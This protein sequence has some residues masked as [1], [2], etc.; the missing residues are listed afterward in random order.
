MRV[1]L[2]SRL[3]DWD[4]YLDAMR[5][6]AFDVIPTPCRSADVESVLTQS[7]RDLRGSVAIPATNPGPHRAANA[8]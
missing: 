4:E 1:V 6:G 2:T 5:L 7:T 3:A 8:G